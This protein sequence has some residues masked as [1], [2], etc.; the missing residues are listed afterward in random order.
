MTPSQSKMRA[1]MGEAEAE[2]AKL[3]D[4]RGVRRLK[5]EREGRRWMHRK[6]RDDDDDDDET[7]EEE[8]RG[9]RGNSS[10]VEEEG[11]RWEGGEE[12]RGVEAAMEEEGGGDGG[13]KIDRVASV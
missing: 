9:A 10:E 7:P 4:G 11:K 1:C 6:C 8:K 3:V 13:G 2:A 12:M 5:S